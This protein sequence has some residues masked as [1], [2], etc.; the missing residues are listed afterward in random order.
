MYQR[1]REQTQDSKKIKKVLKKNKKR[2]D[3]MLKVWYN[4][5]VIKRDYKIKNFLKGV[6][7]YDKDKQKGNKEGYVQSYA[8]IRR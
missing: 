6:V 2:L 4:K 3:K 8:C 5:Y 7:L 1:D